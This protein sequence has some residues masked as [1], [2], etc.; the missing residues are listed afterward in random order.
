[1]KWQDWLDKW[2]MTSLS[3]NAGFLEMQW[4]PKV[5]DRKAAWELYV[6]LLTRIATQ[7]L[8]PEEGDEMS[9]LE[10][11]YSLF[12]LTRDTLRRNQGCGE[13]AKLAVVVL[14]QLIRPFTAKWH[15]LSLLGAFK[16][17]ARCR[18]FRTELAALQRELRQYTIMLA[19][20]AG[21]E[22]LTTL[23]SRR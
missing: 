8:A 4:E 11:V 16:K 5:P 2:G 13:F 14:N 9:A 22:D 19:D 6:E 1:M 3:I 15:R 20:M 21:V 18:E 17:A 23:E 12:S 10:S 7:D